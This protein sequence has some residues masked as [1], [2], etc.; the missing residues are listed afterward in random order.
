VLQG[1]GT[2]TEGFEKLEN[3]KGKELAAANKQERMTTNILM[4]EITSSMKILTVTTC[5]S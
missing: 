1:F 3:W 2:R 5:C 4:I